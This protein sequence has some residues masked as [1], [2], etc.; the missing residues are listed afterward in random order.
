MKLNLKQEDFKF[1]LIGFI[2]TLF[3]MYAVYLLAYLFWWIPFVVA[4][5][6][7]A[8]A[9]GMSLEPYVFVGILQL[10]NFLKK[11]LDK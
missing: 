9:I 6:P 3:I 5:L 4:F 2:P 1:I 8:Y 10:K 11:A 7:L